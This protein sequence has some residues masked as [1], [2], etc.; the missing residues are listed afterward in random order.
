MEN[1]K[2]KRR[3]IIAAS[4]LSAGALL[5]GSLAY[6]ANSGGNS[7]V[8]ADIATDSTDNAPEPQYEDQRAA[9]SVDAE[10]HGMGSQVSK[11]EPGPDVSVE[12]ENANPVDIQATGK[13]YG[14]DVSRYQGNVD[15]R[16][17][18]NKGKRF[19]VVKATEGTT[20]R[21][22]NFS[23]QYNG[24]YNV[25]M[26]RGAYHF[27]RPSSSSGT[28]QANF[29]V[30]H[31]GGWSADGKTLPGTLDIEWNPKGSA[32]Y[33]LSKAQMGK[34]IKDFVNT[35]HHRTGRYPI[36][37]SATSW[38]TQCVGSTVSLS[39]NVP[40]WIARYS[41]KPGTLPHNWSV[42]TIWQYSSK[43]LDSDVFNGSADRL[44]ALAKG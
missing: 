33:G 43:P 39:A 12:V 15:W 29:F 19:A 38:W 2:G 40:L 10:D 28:T 22:P 24:S 3:L 5:V 23:Q 1:R 32:C 35:Y 21:N 7:G 17:W 34:W 42:W 8:S 20:Y 30:N 25:G 41:S 37:Y 9:E 14:I 11:N 27:A 16:S 18:W 36:I 6:A 44:K 4:V 13:V 26:V 31:G